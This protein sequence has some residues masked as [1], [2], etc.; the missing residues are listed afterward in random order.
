M[1]R[2]RIPRPSSLAGVFDR[3]CFVLVILLLAATQYKQFVYNSLDPN[4][5]EALLHHGQWLDS[6]NRNPPHRPFHNWQ[7]PGCMLHNYRGDKIAKCNGN[8]KILFV[9]DSY[10]RQIFWAAVK[11]LDRH[12]A[13]KARAKQLVDMH[14]DISYSKN[15][16]NLKFLWDP[17]LNGSALFGELEDYRRRQGPE[18]KEEV[19]KQELG[20]GSGS[21]RG[22]GRYTEPSRSV[23]IL[24][25]GG[26]WQARHVHQGALKHFKDSID[27]ITA[28]AYPTGTMASLRTIPLSSQEGIQDQLF[29]APV[30]EPRYELLSPSR[31]RT[32]IPEKIDGMNSY[33]EELSL[34]R[35]LNVIWSY[36]NM[37]RGIPEVYLES[38][39]H[40]ID[41]VAERMAD[42]LLN[43]R[44]NAKAT[45]QNGYHNRTCCTGYPPMNMVQIL[46]FFGFVLAMFVAALKGNKGSSGT[47]NPIQGRSEKNNVGRWWLRTQASMD[48]TRSALPA[49]YFLGLFLCFCF[50][51]DRTH[52]LNKVLKQ[53]DVLEFRAL[54]LV[55]FIPC[56]LVI[57]GPPS[58]LG[59]RRSSPSQGTSTQQSFLPRSQAEEWKGWMQVY[60]LV[61][62]YTSAGNELDFYEVLRILIACYLFLTGYGH[63]MYFLHKQDYSLQRVAM[64]LLRLNLLA[65]SL[66]FMVVRPYVSYSFAPLASFWF[67]VV[68]FT[69]RLLRRCNDCLP[70]LVGKIIL[71]AVVVT[72]LVHTNGLLDL[73]FSLFDKTFH[74]TWHTDEWRS[75]LSVD[76][77]IVYV[78]MLVAVLHLRISRLLAQPS[79]SDRLFT[80]VVLHYFWVLKFLA[81]VLSGIAIPV[82]WILTRRS[83]DKRDYDWW[84]PI[85]SWVPVLGFAVLRN[86]TQFLRN[87]HSAAFAWLGRHSLECWLLSQHLWMAGDGSGILSTG[88]WDGDGTLWND[89]WRDLLLFTGLLFW[90]VGRVREASATITAWVTR[91]TGEEM[92]VKD[93][94]HPETSGSELR[95]PDYGNAGLPSPSVSGDKGGE[96]FDGMKGG[97]WRGWGLKRRLVVLGVG[98]WV[99][100]LLS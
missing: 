87:H 17:W 1:P 16:A 72:F 21:G 11:K 41:S 2:L 65:V 62:S 32:I 27:N 89:R 58:I 88:L 12:Y 53:Y 66:S 19:T 74:A 93:K 8:G 59:R 56:A 73:I 38:G 61:Y 9:G 90:V 33:L 69:L 75:M 4:K 26:L 20:S 85:L 42:V 91:G 40:V 18:F 34:H 68:Y 15:G 24:V 67:L 23:V 49:F 22:S 51:A 13:H 98:L 78:G 48:N 77:Y 36:A 57:R 71:S 60:V 86:S 35:D 43:L 52:A 30:L 6:P 31:E 94:K 99:C 14:S 95:L 92:E 10:M 50:M 70:L 96:G 28:T 47:N 81:V 97:A 25:G 76:I 64:V 55:A 63:T 46:T 39:I 7:P 82:F 3:T 100:S 29:F 84:M 79:R 37:T 83:P 44:C 45:Y 5:C 54:F 80:E